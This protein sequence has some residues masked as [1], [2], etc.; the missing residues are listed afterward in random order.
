M[1]KKETY[2][3]KGWLNSDSFLKRSFACL[4]Y[5]F[6][7][8]LIIYFAL[9]IVVIIFAIIFGLIAMSF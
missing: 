4:G 5:Q 8:T 3:Y 7:A 6:V 2:S 1:V 9:V